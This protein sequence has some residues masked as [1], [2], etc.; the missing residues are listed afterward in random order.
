MEEDIILNKIIEGAQKEA[1]SII[2]EAEEKAKKIEEEDKNILMRQAQEQLEIIKSKIERNALSEIEKAEFDA[3][4]SILIE[5]KGLIEIV[6]E[7]VKQ[8]IHDLSD[9]EYINIIDEKIKKYKE[10]KDVEILL[11]KK[12]YE[13][14]KKIVTEYWMT[15][16]DE[17]DKLEVGVIIRCGNIEYNYDF[18]EN[19]EFMDEKIEK[20]IDTILFNL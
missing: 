3:R 20:E 17:T 13:K 16:L 10:E 19:M 8:K 15:V 14:I 6:K 1:S 7:K 4:S 11:P 12:C 18:E 5:R 9:D 2:K